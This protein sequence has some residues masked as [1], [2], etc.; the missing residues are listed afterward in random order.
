MPLA[1]LAA[2]TDEEEEEEAAWSPPSPSAREGPLGLGALA[3]AVGLAALPEDSEEEEPGRA[4]L[5]APRLSFPPPRSG[6]AAAEEERELEAMRRCGV[7]GDFCLPASPLPWTRLA[8][9]PIAAAKAGELWLGASFLAPSLCPALGCTALPT[10]GSAGHARRCCKPCAFVHTR[11]CGNGISCAFCHLCE[12]GEK[13]RRRKEKRDFH[14][15]RL[16][17]RG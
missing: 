6:A 17:G 3:A 12:A 15:A 14:A 4:A 16:V 7:Q 13:Q 5:A 11:G 1:P 2:L 8:Y 9:A 10:V